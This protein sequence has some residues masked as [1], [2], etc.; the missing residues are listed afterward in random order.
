MATNELL[1]LTDE[2]IL[3]KGKH[4]VVYLH[5]FNDK[6]CIKILNNISDTDFDREMKY[7]HALGSK[8]DKMSLLTK[9]FG[10]IETN[11]GKGYIFERVFNFDGSDCKTIQDH[12]QNPESIDD[13]TELLLSFK[14]V[15]IDEKFVTAGMNPKNFLVQRLS[16]IKRQVRIIGK[17]GTAAKIPILYYSDF[18]MIKRARKYWRR[19]VKEISIEYSEIITRDVAAKLVDK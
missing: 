10:E 11:R 13:L 7:R 3:S 1:S 16:P 19:F 9:Y 2:L 14:K 18:L 15:F 6:L 5:P 17:I 4:K 12:L 8:A